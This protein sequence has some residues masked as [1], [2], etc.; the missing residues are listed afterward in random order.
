MRKYEKQDHRYSDPNAH[1][2]KTAFE[3]DFKIRLQNI[4]KKEFK[5]NSDNK[6]VQIRPTVEAVSTK[7]S[8]KIFAYLSIF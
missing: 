7:I 2:I 8:K 6:I 5:K 4:H 3:I 1:K